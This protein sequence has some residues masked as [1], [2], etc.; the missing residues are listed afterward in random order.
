MIETVEASWKGCLKCPR[1]RVRRRV[2]QWRGNPEAHLWVVG[3]VPSE[4]DEREGRPL[5]DAAGKLLDAT[6][7]AAGLNSAEDAFIIN[8]VG[9][10][11]EGGRRPLDFEFSACAPRVEEFSGLLAPS[12]F[13]LLGATV[14]TQLGADF[15][16]GA[17][18][19]VKN[20]SPFLGPA[21]ATYHPVYAQKKGIGHAQLSFDVLKA[22]HLANPAIDA[23]IK[24][25]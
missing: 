2:V 13:L 22:W 11:G 5:V 14:A 1:H 17:I 3:D 23:P 10:R 15:E 8:M 24:R 18:S 19:R 7:K 21:V 6:F 9:C 16:P 25:Q 20:G 4:S 12:A